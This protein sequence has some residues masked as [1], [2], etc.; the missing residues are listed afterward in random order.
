M[1][2]KKKFLLFLTGL[3]MVFSSFAQNIQVFGQIKDVNNEPIIGATVI[4]EGTVNN[5][6]LSDIDGNFTLNVPLNS[7]IFISYVGYVSQ[8]IKVNS[9]TNITVVLIEDAQILDQLVVIGYGTVRK[10]DLTGSVSSVKAD[11][12]TSAP[13]ASIGDA[14]QGRAAGVQIISHGAPGDNVT[15][16]IRG[17]GTIN[18]SNPLVV[19]DGVPTDLGLNAINPNDIAFIDVLKDASAT[20]IY[21]SRGANGVVIISTKKGEEG[22]GKISFSSNFGIQQPTG[23]PVLLNASQY[24]ALSNDML[25]NAGML[26]NPNWSDY[27]SLGMGT[28]WIGELIAPAPMQNYSLSYSGGSQTNDYYVSGGYFDQKGLVRNTDYRRF[29]LQFNGNAKPVKFIKFSNQLTL[30][31]DVKRS[32]DYNIM[33]TM[34]ALPTQPLKFENDT[35]SGP[36]GNVEWVGG[37]RN[38]IGTTEVNKNQT[39]GYNLLGNISAEIDIV[40]GLKFKTLGGLDFKTWFSDSFTPKYNWKP[41]AVETSSKYQSSNRS[42]T[43]LWDNYFTYD[44][45]F[46]DLHKFNSMVGTSAQTNQFNFMS[47]TVNT[48]LRDENNQLDNGSVIQG[49]NG[50]S[51]EWSLLSLIARMNYT[52]DEKYIL[53]ATIRRDGSSRFG[54]NN[55]WGTFPSF[56]FAWRLSEEDWFPRNQILNDSKLRLGYGVSGNQNIG[57]Y[58][59]AAIY[60]IGVYNFNDNTVPTLIASRMPNPNIKWERVEQYNV[61]ADLGLLKQRV[62]VSIDAYLKNTNGMLVPMAVPISTGYSDIYVPSINA[63]KMQN[64]GVE[65]SVFSKNITG[66]EFNW[67]T[68]VNLTFN[69][70]KILDLNSDSPMYGNSIENSNITIQSEDHPMNSFYGFVVDGIFQNQVEVDNASVQIQ[71]GTAPGDLRFKDIDNNGVI[72]DND[73]TYIGNPN[74]DLIYSM[75]NRFDWK[76]FDLEIYLQG[77][78]GNQVFNANRMTLEGMKVSDNQSIAVLNRWVGEGTS[79]NMP[80]SI[81]NDP[82]KNTRASNRFVE[83]GSYLRIKNISLGYTLPS[84]LIRNAYM[85]SARIYFSTQNVFTFTGYSGID[86]EVGINGIDYGAYPL[87]RTISLGLNISF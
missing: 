13:V 66:R 2:L 31:H 4:Q 8:Q 84:S 58:E 30:S 44:N 68:T 39:K 21:G 5:G 62:T 1:K 37:I 67:N 52:Y 6:V 26:P 3:S 9:Q 81:Y 76:G 63:G 82:N 19:I 45:T 27:E 61:G 33:S 48:F 64:R 15:M 24:A 74:P 10:S 80:R 17:L 69:K 49:L 14:L 73:R 12:I 32:G 55:K 87:T 47:G 50:N 23:M 71:G 40:K 38:P 42:T 29:T 83:N 41:I 79:N 77:N 57:N 7:T 75:S 51:S 56:S 20:A 46:G 35:W 60:D 25:R 78:L 72:N 53:T 59:F 22:K 11:D 54:K 43:L 18:D 70:N 86:P 36:V 85:E 34:R 65:L 16:K 28:D